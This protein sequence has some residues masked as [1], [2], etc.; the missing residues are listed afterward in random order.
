MGMAM[1]DDNRQSILD[2]RRLVQRILSGNIPS[3]KELDACRDILKSQCDEE[4]AF[5]ALFTLL[6]GALADP[7]YDIDD[8]QMVVPI[9][10]A[11]ARGELTA[12]DLL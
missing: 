6:Q 5:A 3:G 9:L 1:N 2:Q 10:K 11:L 4:S 7:F 8:T 12:G